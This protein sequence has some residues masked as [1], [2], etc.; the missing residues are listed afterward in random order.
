M[1]FVAA[2][3]LAM[4]SLHENNWLVAH[5]LEKSSWETQYFWALYW[6]ATLISTTGFGDYAAVNLK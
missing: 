4:V 2:V 1:H 5:S 3:L 6:S